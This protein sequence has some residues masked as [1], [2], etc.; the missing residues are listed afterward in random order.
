MLDPAARIKNKTVEEILSQWSTDLDRHVS[1]FLDQSLLLQQW[2]EQLLSN[3]DAIAAIQ[4][5]AA[6]IQAKQAAINRAIDVCDSEQKELNAHLAQLEATLDTLPA[7]SAADDDISRRETYQLAEEVDAHLSTLSSTLGHTIATLNE[8]VGSVKVSKTG[9]TDGGT[10]GGGGGGV[11]LMGQL[12][13]I[14]NVH[15]Q[16][17]QWLAAQAEAVERS[18]ER[19]TQQV[20]AVDVM[21]DRRHGGRGV[22]SGSIGVGAGAGAGGGRLLAGGNRVGGRY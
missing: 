7:A 12:T 2:D 6:D 20:A 14:L 13:D 22:N 18:L 19:T 16:S 4:Q 11:G 17:L 1:S 15:L 10:G 5:Q 3:A 8:R 21:D 9:V